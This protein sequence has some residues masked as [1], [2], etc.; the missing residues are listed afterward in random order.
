MQLTRDAQYVHKLSATLSNALIRP[1][2]QRSNPFHCVSGRL[3]EAIRL[4]PREQSIA[5][6]Q[7]AFDLLPQHWFETAPD[8]DRVNM[9]RT[10]PVILSR[11]SI[12]SSKAGI[13][14][15]SQERADLRFR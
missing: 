12:P 8:P 11:F 10:R 9:R 15:L 6:I 1:A 3:P 5:A 14:E 4:I 13:G 7:P 2:V